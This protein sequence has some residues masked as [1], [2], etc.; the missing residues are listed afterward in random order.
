LLTSQKEKLKHGEFAPWVAQNLPFSQRT[1]RNY[2]LVFRERHKLKTENVTDLSKAYKVLRRITWSRE[3]R[4][5]H[6]SNERKFLTLT[7]S[8]DD[9]QN[10]VIMTTVDKAKEL[11]ETSSTARALEHISYDWFMSVADDSELM[12]IR[13][14]KK[15]FEEIYNIKITIKRK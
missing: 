2:M 8:M 10:E 4:V 14:A 7:L 15:L 6:E 1:A 3:E 9:I 12:P 11:L 13:A 5:D